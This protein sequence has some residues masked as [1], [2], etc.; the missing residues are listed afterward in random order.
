VAGLGITGASVNPARSF[1]PALVSGEWADIWVYIV[2]PAAGAILAWV[3][4]K[5]IITGDLNFTVGSGESA[6]ATVSP[7]AAS[8][9]KP[10]TTPKRPAATTRKPA[11]TAKK[12]ATTRAAARG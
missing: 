3:L 4:Y 11:A 12:P 6:A 10:A 7:K 8:A 1:G 5:V 9:G 2:G